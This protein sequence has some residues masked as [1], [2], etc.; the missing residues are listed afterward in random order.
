ME[1]TKKEKVLS[2]LVNFVG[3][4][5]DFSFKELDIIVQEVTPES[6]NNII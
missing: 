5:E 3:K 4:E 1:I 6:K 2:T